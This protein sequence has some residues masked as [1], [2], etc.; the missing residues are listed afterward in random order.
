MIVVQKELPFKTQEFRIGTF[1]RR[2]VMIPRLLLRCS[3]SI[4]VRS[5]AE[6]CSSTRRQMVSKI[7]IVSVNA[8]DRSICVTV[9]LIGLEVP[10]LI[11]YL[12]FMRSRVAA[13]G[14]I[15]V[16]TYFDSLG[17]WDRTSRYSS[18]AAVIYLHYLF[19]PSYLHTYRHSKL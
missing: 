13:F 5:Q 15:S 1:K 16:R 17:K 19:H 4:V 2:V 8:A 11:I 14:C 18:A 6:G 12:L 7:S 10:I 9:I 3:C